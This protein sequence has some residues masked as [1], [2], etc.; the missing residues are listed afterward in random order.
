MG[1]FLEAFRSLAGAGQTLRF[2][3]FV[4]L[5]LYHPEL[6]YYRRQRPRVGTGPGTDFYTA[7]NSAP[8]FGEMILAAIAQ[9]LNGEDLRRYT[10]VEIGA[11]TPGGILAGVAHP[12]GA[13]R[14]VRVGEL[15]AVEG[16]CVVFSNEL[17]DAQ[18]FRRF[19]VRGGAWRELGVRAGAEALEEVELST[20]LPDFLPAGAPEGYHL[21]APTE[22]VTLAASIARRSWQGL[23]LACDY[24]KSWAELAHATPIGTA[25]AYRRHRQSN[26]LLSNPG[27]QDLTCHL[28]WDWLIQALQAE[29][30]AQPVVESQEAFFVL[31]AGRYIEEVTAQEATRFSEKKLSLLQLLHPSHLGRK[32]QILHAVRQ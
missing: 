17:F 22:A 8:V 7:S 31:H 5:A 3:R 30:F 16:R 2:D 21:D 14:T 9:L 13:A 25:R 15:F 6:G 10:F 24:G 18:P 20:A 29:G 32:F 28:C 12:F 23:F 11:E 1:T 26:D 19:R 4:E 27:E